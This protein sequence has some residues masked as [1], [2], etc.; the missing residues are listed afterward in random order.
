MGLDHALQRLER[1]R[2]FIPVKETESLESKWRA[3]PH[4]RRC[5]HFPS[6]YTMQRVEN[7]TTVHTLHPLLCCDELD[8]KAF[9][10]N[11]INPRSPLSEPNRAA[12]EWLQ[13]ASRSRNEGGATRCSFAFIIAAGRGRVC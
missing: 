12:A 7:S 2:E 5:Q 6:C 10:A 3:L 13:S 11:Q 4:A 8:S 1:F 9:N